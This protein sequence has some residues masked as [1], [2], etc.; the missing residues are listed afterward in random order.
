MPDTRK[1]VATD[2]GDLSV[3]N[4]NTRCTM[5]FSAANGDI[6]EIDVPVDLFLELAQHLDACA[7]QIKERMRG[8][9]ATAPLINHPLDM[10]VGLL[11]DHVPPSVGRIR[12]VDTY[13]VTMDAADRLGANRLAA[14]GITEHELIRRQ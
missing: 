13:R 14:T 2:I 12:S 11:T 10:S 5:R 7:H 9:G 8:S 4:Q 1:F 3:V 6:Q